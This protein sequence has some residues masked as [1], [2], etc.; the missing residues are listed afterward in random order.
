VEQPYHQLDHKTIKFVAGQ[1]IKGT[2]VVLT[3][4][5]FFDGATS[6]PLGMIIKVGDWCQG[7]LRL[8]QHDLYAVRWWKKQGQWRKL[9]EFGSKHTDSNIERVIEWMAHDNIDQ[10]SDVPDWHGVEFV[11]QDVFYF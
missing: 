1:Q 6:L 9:L 8:S 10:T 11:L 3:T 4:K 5:S 2:C 7:I